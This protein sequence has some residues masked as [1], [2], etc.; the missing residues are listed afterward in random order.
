MHILAHHNTCLELA[1]CDS[2]SKYVDL[3]LTSCCCFFVPVPNQYD[4]PLQTSQGSTYTAITLP[5]GYP[6]Q[7]G[8][9]GHT[10]Y[11]PNQQ[12]Q[13]ML[14]ITQPQSVSNTGSMLVDTSLSPQDVSKWEALIKAKESMLRQK[15]QMIEK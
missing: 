9:G 3:G 4:N 8:I 5:Q 12:S 6:S 10:V 14:L 13:Q 1:L 15:D 11:V 2:E 7:A